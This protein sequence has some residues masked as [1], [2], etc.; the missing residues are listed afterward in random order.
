MKLKEL[1]TGALLTALAIIIPIQ[2]GF[3]KIVI[4]PFSATLASHVPMFIAMTI[5]PAVA[6]LVGIGSTLGF[7]MTAPPYI[8]ARAASHIVVGFIGAVLIRRRM[9]YVKAFALTLPIHAILEALVVIPFGW[10]AYQVLVVTGVGTALHHIADAA[11]SMSLVYVL[12]PYLKLNTA[13]R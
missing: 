10:T 6:V 1:V 5:S 3:L 8:A 2:F 13:K 12:A 11:I 9:P 7:L 4:P